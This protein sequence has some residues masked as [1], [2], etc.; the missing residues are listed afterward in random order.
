MLRLGTGE[1]HLGVILVPAPQQVTQ[2][3]AGNIGDVAVRVG[4]IILVAV[5]IED[6]DLL[7]GKVIA[8]AQHLFVPRIQNGGAAGLGQRVAVGFIVHTDNT[9][10]VTGNIDLFVQLGR[11]ERVLLEQNVVH[12]AEVAHGVC[13]D[14]V[15]SKV[16]FAVDGLQHVFNPLGVR[17]EIGVLVVL[18]HYLNDRILGGLRPTTFERD[19]A[20]GIDYSLVDLVGVVVRDRVLNEVV[21]GVGRPAVTVEVERGCGAGRSVGGC[22]G[23]F[24]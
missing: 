3:P 8:V 16:V 9:V 7:L 13:D 14:V 19:L 12:E 21:G 20:V 24:G 11:V 4:T 5:N 18:E 22:G 6:V 17:L 10:E 2:R 23:A 15:V 1:H